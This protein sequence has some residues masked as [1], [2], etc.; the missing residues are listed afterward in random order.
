MSD[1]DHNRQRQGHSP[2]QPPHV[3]P[4]EHVREIEK[5]LQG[6]AEYLRHIGERLRRLDEQLSHLEAEDDRAVDRGRGWPSGG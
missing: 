1:I 6:M 2:E 4:R 3:T 5:H